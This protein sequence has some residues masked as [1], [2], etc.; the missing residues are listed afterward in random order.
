MS[1]TKYNTRGTNLIVYRFQYV[2]FI[3]LLYTWYFPFGY[4]MNTPSNINYNIV[5]QERLIF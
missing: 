1:C 5:T 3:N 2:Y 4:L